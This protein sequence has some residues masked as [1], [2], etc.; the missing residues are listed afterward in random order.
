MKKHQVEI[1]NYCL[2]PVGLNP[3]EDVKGQFRPWQKECIEKIADAKRA[4][5]IAPTGSGKS[6]VARARGA[7]ILKSD[8]RLKHIVSVPQG[9]IASSFKSLELEELSWCSGEYLIDTSDIVDKLVEFITD[10]TRADFN[11][12]IRVCTHQALV[13]AFKKLQ[14][15]NRLSALEDVFLTID[16]IHHSSSTEED[17]EIVVDNGLGKI[18]KYFFK[19]DLHLDMF[20]ATWMRSNYLS[21]IPSRYKEEIDYIKYTLPIDKHLEGM[22]HL[23][24][25]SIRFL[26]GSIEDSLQQIY[27]DDN[28]T[29][30]IVYLPPVRSTIMGGYDGK[31]SMR[32]Q[33]S[34]ALGLPKTSDD[35]MTEVIETG[36]IPIRT[37]DLVTEAG[38]EKRKN[39]FLQSIDSDKAPDLLWALNMCKEGFDWPEASRAFVIGPRGSMI[40]IIQMLGRLLRDYPGKKRTEFNIVLPI[41]KEREDP[42][43]IRDYLKIM[44]SSLVVEWQFRRPELCDLKER[45]IVDKVFIRDPQLGYKALASCLDSG[46]CSDE[47]DDAIAVIRRGLDCSRVKLNKDE[48]DTLAPVLARMLS[49]NLTDIN[50]IEFEPKLIRDVFGKVRSW[51][52][53]FGYKSLAELRETIGKRK[54]LTEEMI[55]EAAQNHNE[56]TGIWPC[57]ATKGDIENFPVK[58][59]NSVNQSLSV[60]CNG[61]PG[62][63]SLAKLLDERVPG[64]AKIIPTEELIIEAIKTYFEQTGKIP[65]QKTVSPVPGLPGHSWSSLGAALERG[66]YGLPGGSSLS[67]IADSIYLDRVKISLTEELIVESI[68]VYLEQTGNLPHSHNKDF[69]PNLLNYNWVT[70]DAALKFGRYGLPGNSSLAILLNTHFSE[71]KALT[72]ENIV[73]SMVIY[74]EQTGKWPT[75]ITSGKAPGLGD[76]TWG[77]LNSSLKRGS[78]GLSVSGSSI[79]KLLNK[80]LSERKNLTEDLIWEV[81][82]EWLKQTGKWPNI[83]VV[84]KINHLKNMT[85][86]L[87]NKSLKEGLHGL[88][89]GSSLLKLLTERGASIKQRNEICLTEALIWKAAQNWFK[90]TGSWPAERTIGNIPELPNCNWVQLNQSLRTGLHGLPGGSSLAKLLVFNGV[91]N[92]SCKQILTEDMILRAA[93]NWFK[94]T[95]RWPTRRT[96]GKI[97]EFPG[98]VWYG[99]NRI[100][101]EK[102]NKTLSQL[103]NERLSEESAA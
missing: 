13:A 15:N 50:S 32:K 70:I 34:C 63:S 20:T 80:Y 31:H 7:L 36:G 17:D 82:Q 25:V 90:R 74:H 44:M 58:N 56:Q 76:H 48:K 72:E 5:V 16:E 26:I 14:K 41:M 19:H 103:S 88:P 40:D 37:L 100:L 95:G 65:L 49:R 91:E 53:K 3:C 101:K 83:G 97:P 27:E 39:W 12:R 64:R 62:G 87:V 94:Q 51:A 68:K 75:S 4:V 85:W 60:G 89:G 102:S 69:V 54:V 71:Q 35:D 28:L 78:H 10:R 59:W 66:S 38:R 24:E 21:I 79:P 47:K 57:I 67:K 52:F 77:S 8:P 2:I 23:R 43:K 18:V 81:A 61:L 46:I 11:N 45:K 99:V 42:D 55:W 92:N 98:H 1:E 30:T 96:I 93:Q 33:L 84:G 29:K 6:T 73:K 22:S 86:A 9:I